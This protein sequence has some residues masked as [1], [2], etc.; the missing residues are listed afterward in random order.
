LILRDDMKIDRKTIEHLEALARIELDDAEREKLADQLDRIV[1][2]VEKLNEL[3]TSCIEYET[4]RGSQPVNPDF[5][6]SW[7]GRKK[8]LEQAPVCENSFFRVPRVIDRGE[9]G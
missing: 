9:D 6:S 7:R 3:D 8:A 4:H 1:K 5:P 2:F